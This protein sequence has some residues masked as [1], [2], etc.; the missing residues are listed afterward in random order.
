MQGGQLAIEGGAVIGP[1]PLL[2][3][4]QAAKATGS[5][6]TLLHRPNAQIL[7]SQPSNAMA[8][9]IAPSYGGEVSASISHEARAAAIARAMDKAAFNSINPLYSQQQQ[10]HLMPPQDESQLLQP[11]PGHTA[12]S[13]YQASAY[14]NPANTSHPNPAYENQQQ[15][16]PSMYSANVYD[17]QATQQLQQSLCPG[18][19]APS[20]QSLYPATTHDN[21]ASQHPHYQV[22]TYDNTTSQQ[23]HYQAST[24][25]NAASQQLHY[26]A[27]THDNTASHQAAY[28][29]SAYD[30]TASQHPH[31]QASTYDITASQQPHYQASAYDHTASQQPHYQASGYETTMNQQAHYRAPM[32]EN[33]Q[34]QY[35]SPP[36]SQTYYTP[37]S[38][39]LQSTYS[40]AVQQS[41]VQSSASMMSNQYQH[42]QVQLQSGHQYPNQHQLL[43]QGDQQHYARPSTEHS[44]RLSAD[45][46]AAPQYV[47]DSKQALETT[48]PPR[49]GSYQQSSMYSSATS[50]HQQAIPAV[51][52]YVHNADI[53]SEYQPPLREYA[54]TL[55]VVTS[56]G[57]TVTAVPTV[58]AQ[59]ANIYYPPPQR[60][61][62]PAQQ[63]VDAP[64][65][66]DWQ[67][68]NAQM[69][70]K[71]QKVTL[72]EA[73]YN[74]RGIIFGVPGAFTPVCSQRHVPGFRDAMPIL[75]EA[76]EYVACV[77]V[78]DPYV[79]KAWAKELKIPKDIVMISDWEGKF[80]EALGLELD[81]SSY[82]MG[83]RCRRFC[84][85]VSQGTIVWFG[86]ENDAFVDQVALILHRLHLLSDTQLNEIQELALQL[87]AASN[88]HLGST[89]PAAETAEPPQNQLEEEE[90][91]YS[92]D[93][94]SGRPLEDEE[95]E[96]SEGAMGTEDD[97][98][99]E[100]EEEEEEDSL[101]TDEEE[102]AMG[103]LS[104]E[105]ETEEETEQETEE[106]EEEEEQ[107][108]R[109]AEM[110]SSSRQMIA[111]SAD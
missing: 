37:S 102:E 11:S 25:D 101:A 76:V 66:V 58:S 7:V 2:S 53:P 105:E 3:T 35:M 40:P 15:P 18:T 83:I 6:T 46:T 107:E 54:A 33:S 10:Q 26:Q 47:R 94:E 39:Q 50:V 79:L 86:L 24:Y 61:A 106:D 78:N 31:Y 43:R 5:H 110:M 98:A 67:I 68:P 12:T 22:S 103:R 59:T 92:E 65:P 70:V 57:S 60:P 63:V 23:P 64:L 77:A 91:V 4:L 48:A 97:S 20:P 81:A 87:E 36:M 44:A 75:R 51:A 38:Q 100:E 111:V 30:N 73:L 42:Q 71:G 85:L 93:E 72:H 27:S 109:A 74:R 95:V 88:Q 28:Q 41:T 8:R 104:I 108:K 84:I 45:H 99:R 32:Y 62:Y 16:Q 14:E 13:Q 55:P 80:T 90:E 49:R 34:T 89:A 82:H 19:T 56:G 96:E 29:A 9:I 1:S 69:T 52:E 17:N 21:T